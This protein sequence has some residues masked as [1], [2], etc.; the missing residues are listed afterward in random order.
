M[1]RLT[2][3]TLIKGVFYLASFS[4]LALLIHQTITFGSSPQLLISLGADILSIITFT[5]FSGPTISDI[6]R[7][8]ERIEFTKKDVSSFVQNI[9]NIFKQLFPNLVPSHDR[10]LKLMEDTKNAYFKKCERGDFD[11][12]DSQIKMNITSDLAVSALSE[13]PN[14]LEDGVKQFFLFILLRKLGEGETARSFIDELDEKSIFDK[15]SWQYAFCRCSLLFSSKRFEPNEIKKYI[16]AFSQEQVIECYHFLKGNL[17]LYKG[18]KKLKQ[19]SRY[20]EFYEALKEQ[21]AEMLHKNE[22]S[23]VALRNAIAEEKTDLI[24]VIKWAESGRDVLGGKFDRLLW[25][26]PAS[27][28]TIQISPIA[29]SP[30]SK[31]FDL[32]RWIEQNFELDEIDTPYRLVAIKFNIKDMVVRAYKRSDQFLKDVSRGFSSRRIEDLVFSQ[33]ESLKELLDGSDLALLVPRFSSEAKGRIREKDA[34]IRNELSIKGFRPIKSP[35]DFRFYADEI[36]TIIEVLSNLK[37]DG[38]RMFNDSDAKEIAA[39]FVNNAKR[40][41]ELVSC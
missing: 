29:D 11:R 36:D 40:L 1:V 17:A 22:I 35:L 12:L 5:I 25:A 37:S 9:F 27:S 8:K 14:M 3:P 23:H 24:C 13:F 30:V 6:L 21:V 39:A 31:D 20:K 16:D 33:A 28:R 2:N 41:A 18:M 4:I 38:K 10:C 34:V 26:S 32:N 7:R 15:S 19:D